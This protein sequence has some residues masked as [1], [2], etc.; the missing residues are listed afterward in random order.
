MKDIRVHALIDRGL[1][2]MPY[3]FLILISPYVQKSAH[4]H[5]QNFQIPTMFISSTAETAQW[6]SFGVHQDLLVPPAQ[7]RQ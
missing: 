3:V 7:V 2:L 5:D 4:A 6:P 1:S